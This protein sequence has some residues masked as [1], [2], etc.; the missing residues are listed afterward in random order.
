MNV[1][2]ISLIKVFEM[3]EATRP[4]WYIWEISHILQTQTEMENIGDKSYKVQS[5]KSILYC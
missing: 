3:G 2:P 5:V 4:L 1:A